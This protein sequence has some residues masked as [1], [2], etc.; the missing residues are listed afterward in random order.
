LTDASGSAQVE[1]LVRSYEALSLEWDAAQNNA[2]K[3]NKLFDAKRSIASK[4]R[5]TKEGR[6][7]LETLL[8]HE[9]RGVRMSAAGAALAWDSEPAIATLEELSSPR[10]RHTLDAET[11]LREY[12]AGRMRFDW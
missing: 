10:G 7:G 5:G 4:L 11:T 3:A 1:D 9:N 6:Q 2:K 12:R 8:Q